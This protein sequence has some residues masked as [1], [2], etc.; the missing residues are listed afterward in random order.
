MIPSTNHQPH[1]RAKR[2]NKP[3]AGGGKLRLVTLDHLDNRTIASRRVREL[4]SK[5]TLD[6]TGG[7][8]SQLTE[9]TKQLI[10]NAGML[11]GIIE[12]S[13]AAWLSGDPVD[14]A[15]YYAALNTQRRILLTLGLDRRQRDVT[16]ET[17]QQISD[18]MAREDSERTVEQRI[19]DA[20]E[21]VAQ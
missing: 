2:L 17:M 7:D 9:A 14:L 8:N 1:K 20:A 10:Q 18:R 4:I 11:A 3:K 13:A 6:V 5:I 15:S 19:D 21:E 16:P 12:S